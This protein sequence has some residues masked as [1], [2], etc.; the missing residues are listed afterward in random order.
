MK[1]ASQIA[2]FANLT[3]RNQGASRGEGRTCR[4]CYWRERWQCGGSIIQYCRA[5][6]SKRTFNGLKKIK[7]TNPACELYKEEEK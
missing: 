2:L 3:S 1:I 5:I 6:P 7:V 4:Y